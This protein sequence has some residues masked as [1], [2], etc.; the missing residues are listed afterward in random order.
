MLVVYHTKEAIDETGEWSR[1]GIRKVNE[2]ENILRHLDT[3]DATL[4][5]PAATSS[6]R[7]RSLCPYVIK[8]LVRKVEF[9]CLVNL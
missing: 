2:V 1:D 8:T 7:N 5:A 3:T 4:D 9:V 6:L